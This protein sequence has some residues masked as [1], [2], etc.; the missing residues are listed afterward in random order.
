MKP[1]TDVFQQAR[2]TL[3]IPEAW[4]MLGLPGEPK[5]TCKSPFRDER[6]ASFSIHAD[7]KKWKDHGADI[8]GDVVEFIKSAIVGDYSAVREWLQARIGIIEAP[9]AT[10]KPVMPKSIQYPAATTEGTERHWR[11]LAVARELYQTTAEILAKFGMVKF[12]HHE[13]KN[14]FIITDATNRNA[15]I[16]R[17]DKQPFGN[18]KKAYPLTGVDKSWLVGAAFLK[19]S[20]EAHVL[21]VEGATDFLTAWD[22]NVLYRR[23][24]GRQAPK[25]VPVALLGAGCKSLHADCAALLAG[26]HVRLVPDGDTAGDGMREHWESL[27]LKN[28][29]TVD[30]IEMPRGK[31][32]TDIKNEIEPSNIFTK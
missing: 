15:E 27:L 21:L 31:D 1:A 5:P 17:I 19:H 14:C 28:G 8:G 22:M 20:P 3:T 10:N 24:L 16:R 2:Q 6:T 25:W 4:V 30:A 18:G 32:L 29:C 13:G 26:R 9:R 7:G 12:M 23:K 11:A